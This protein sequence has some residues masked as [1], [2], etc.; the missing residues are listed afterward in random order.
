MKVRYYIPL[1]IVFLSA[2]IFSSCSENISSQAPAE[3]IPLKEGNRWIYSYSEYDSAHTLL[4]TLLDTVVIGTPTVKNGS[5]WYPYVSI[6]F[7]INTLGDTTYYKNDD[8]GLWELYLST[9]PKRVY[10]YPAVLG[11]TFNVHTVY[12][13]DT[14]TLQRRFTKIGGA[15]NMI[16]VPA[17]TFTTIRYDGHSQILNPANMTVVQD[18]VD[19]SSYVS[20]GIGLVKGIHHYVL[21]THQ[22]L[23]R[24]YTQEVVLVSYKF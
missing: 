4:W 15:Q 17:G 7:R 3:I 22:G 12:F 23:K 6:T 5:T 20:P 21:S 14:S 24:K 18:N 16:T 9:N 10:K 2:Y 1:V 19:D 8:D 11:D 13:P